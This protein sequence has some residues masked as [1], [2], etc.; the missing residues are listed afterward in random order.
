MLQYPIMLVK[1]LKLILLIPLEIFALVVSLVF[2]FVWLLLLPLKWCCPGGSVVGCTESI[3]K[4]LVK[5]PVNVA[6]WVLK[7]DSS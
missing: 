2:L 1:L 5:L 3:F 6:K 7:D 4:N